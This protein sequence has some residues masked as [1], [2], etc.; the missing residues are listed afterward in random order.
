[1]QFVIY[2]DNGGQFHWSLVDEDR[3]SLAVSATAFSSRAD[4]LRAATHVHQRAGSA[5]PTKS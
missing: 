3:V 2:Q 5:T 4:A 1:M